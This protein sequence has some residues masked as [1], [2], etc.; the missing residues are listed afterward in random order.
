M[1]K[2]T[3][4][5]KKLA[6]ELIE[7]IPQ[8]DEEGLAFL[9]E[10]GRVHLYN[11]EVEKLNEAQQKVIGASNRK[12]ETAS[13]KLNKKA[14]TPGNEYN[15]KKSTASGSYHLQHGGNWKLFTEEEMLALVRIA[16][17]RKPQAEVISDMVD[18][19]DKERP[20]TYSDLNIN[21]DSDEDIKGL[22]KFLQKT[23][24]IRR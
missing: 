24:A 21:P 5:H 2:E 16:K 18:W 1:A 15:I 9:I 12:V 20:D 8:L 6:Q 7:L 13:K 17:E 22:I 23:F 19:L 11:M 4:L 10:Q 14:A 3:K